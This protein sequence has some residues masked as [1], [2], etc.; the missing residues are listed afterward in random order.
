MYDN[1]RMLHTKDGV[2]ISDILAQGQAILETFNEDAP[3][4]V[5]S[6][7]GQDIDEQQFR[8][9]VGDM[10]WEELAEGEHPRTGDLASKEMAFSVKTYGR[11]LGMTQELIEDHSADYVLR[12][13]DRLVEG[14]LKAEHDVVL[15]TVRNGWAD[16][17]ALWFGA[18]EYGEY[19]FSETHD[20]TFAS[21]QELFERNGATDTDPHT[22][23]EHILEMV[24]ELEHHGKDATLA[25]VGFDV[26]KALHK[27]LTLD[28]SYNI[29]VFERMRTSAFPDNGV[30]IFGVQVARSA[31]LDPT[32]VHV[33][34]AEERPLYFH[35]RRPVQ[36]TNGE[37]GG[38]VGDPATLLGAYG[39]ARYGAIVA[40]P[41]AG[42]K[43]EAADNIGTAA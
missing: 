27:E 16:G 6:L 8:V 15:E 40:D 24:E 31:Y 10:T 30:E 35:E 7:L 42:V 28:A 37:Y 26:A 11:S 13:F 25:L 21:T 9:Y 43:V 19:S 12:R 1:K 38:P 22:V 20:H 34:A 17:T 14:A 32:E 5:R 3:R 18:T 33:I 29:P 41:L 36:I 39:S 4:V 23:S 2:P